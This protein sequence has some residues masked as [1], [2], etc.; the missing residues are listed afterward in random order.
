VLN[1]AMPPNPQESPMKYLL[2]L[3]A[4]AFAPLGAS[5]A[6]PDPMPDTHECATVDDAC[7]AQPDTVLEVAAVDAL[8]QVA[9]LGADTL[10]GRGASAL[11][12]DC[13]GDCDPCQPD[14]EPDAIERLH[15]A[16]T[17]LA[18]LPLPAVRVLAR[19]RVLAELR[20][21]LVEELEHGRLDIV[22]RIPA[23][24]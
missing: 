24:I 22:R 5:A 11:D 8:D 7:D 21:Q 20:Y 10:A 3:L 13:D 2:M 4:L 12:N 18:R 6:P 17:P 16:L 1:A 15:A 9:E 23:T 14:P 19:G